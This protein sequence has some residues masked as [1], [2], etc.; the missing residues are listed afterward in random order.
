[1]YGSYQQ[2]GL[3]GGMY[4]FVRTPLPPGTIVDSL[5]R[6]VWKIDKEQPITYFWTMDRVVSASM[7]VTRFITWLLA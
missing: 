3:I 6:E 2:A 7:F 1:L 4:L 5:R